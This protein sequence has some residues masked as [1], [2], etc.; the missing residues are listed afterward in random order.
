VPQDPHL[1]FAATKKYGT[2]AQY[3]NFIQIKTENWLD[4]KSPEHFR[5]HLRAYNDGK[6]DDGDYPLPVVGGAIY[7]LASFC[8]SAR[9]HNTTQY[10]YFT[11]I[12]RATCDFSVSL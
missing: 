7:V 5:K 10:T 1:H 4:T 12:V 11:S 3:M 6:R 2:R 9:A 8:R